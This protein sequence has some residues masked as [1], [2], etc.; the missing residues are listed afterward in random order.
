MPILGIVSS[1]A[2]MAALPLLTWSVFMGWMAV[3]FLV[4][5]GYARISRRFG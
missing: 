3:G 1:L 2:L 5:F 4:Y